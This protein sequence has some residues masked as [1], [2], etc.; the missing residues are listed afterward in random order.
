MSKPVWA[1]LLFSLLLHLTALLLVDHL[2]LAEQEVG[3]FRARLA[4]APRFVQQ[5]KLVTT[6]PTAISVDMEY[7]RSQ[8]NPASAPAGAMPLVAAAEAVAP[9]PT[10]TYDPTLPKRDGAELVIEAMPD[11]TAPSVNDT[12][13]TESMELL[14]IE[15]IMRA[16]RER[17]VIIADVYSRRDTRG[18]VKFTPLRL[19]GV[20]SFALD[21]QGGRPVLGDLARYIRDHTEVKAELRGFPAEYFNSP[22]L[23]KDPV[24]FFFPGIQRGATNGPRVVLN[25]EEQ[26]FMGEYLRGGGMLFIDAGQGSGDRRFLQAMVAMLKG[27]L[28]AEGRLFAL[29]ANHAVYH[30][31][32]SYENGFPGELKRPVIDIPG[33]NWYYPDQAPCTSQ[34]PRGLYGVERDGQTVAVI[35]DLELHRF[36]SGLPASCPPEEGEE[37]AA[38]GEGGG[39][40]EEAPAPVM[41]PYLEA[42]TNIVFHALTQPGGVAV[43]R[44]A[45][46]WGQRRAPTG[47]PA[48]ESDPEDESVASDDELFDDLEASLAFVRAPAGK[49]IG[50]EGLRVRVA[51]YGEV[52]VVNGRLH[53]IL[54]HNLPAGPRWIEVEYGDE[55][56]GLEIDLRGG[57]VTT[58]AFVVR[59][60][61][62]WTS[63]SLT[64][65][66]EYFATAGW[67]ER[68]GD[69]VVE[70]IFAELVD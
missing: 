37:A 56:Q 68:F 45:P 11:P 27:V 40:G 26:K 52:E 60:L 12:V 4:T 23:L 7:V 22:P 58:V 31:F 18:F 44:Q 17:A 21:G 1:S 46:S 10:D 33:S 66:Q 9:P 42:A 13:A 54:L 41:S 38:G 51:G 59:G 34:P 48:V 15:D 55:Q 30:A 29:P 67:S 69:L 61:G 57:K 49:R 5:Q 19:N 8:A 24:H 14:R 28:G 3:V 20:W 50:A 2:L 25:E 47:R 65:Q 64:P 16:D 63:L 39:E 6:A 62:F 53:G 36:W 32:Y 43:K 35:S 70:E